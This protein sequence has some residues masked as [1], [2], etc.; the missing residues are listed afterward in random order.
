MIRSGGFPGCVCRRMGLA[1]R[2]VR[3]MEAWFERMGAEYAYMATDKSNEASLRLFT[4]R[5]GYSKFRTPSLL[6]HPVHA[7]RRRVPRR[8]AVFRLGARDAE[9]L[10][11]GRFAHVEFFPADIGAVLGNQLS[12]G[13]FLAVI[14]D[15]GRWR[16]G[17]GAG[18]SASW[19]PAGV[20]GAGEPL[21]LRGVFRLELR[22]A[23][24]LRRAAA[25]RRARWTA[26][27]GGCASR[28][29][30]TSSARSP[31]GSCTASAATAPTPRWP[32][33]R[34]SRR[35]STWR[36]AGR[37]PWPSRWRPATRSAAASRTGAASR[38]PRTCGA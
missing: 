25:A 7:H 22:G 36:A 3:R 27:R 20:V 6:V 9:R 24:R 16:H 19:R 21:G 1:L 35:S 15:D 2:M 29:C 12:I 31:G 14:D 18:P 17:S 37:P 38:A 8:A 23:S 28:P 11:D 34:C 5:C 13:T 33:R 30:R 26:R 10:Y 32:P 4:V